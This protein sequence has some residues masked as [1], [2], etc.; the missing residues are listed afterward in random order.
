MAA[1]KLAAP[2]PSA[3]AM[4]A[5]DETA[6]DL[7][8]LL[9]SSRSSKLPCLDHHLPGQILSP[10]H[11]VVLHGEA[12]SGKSVLL[13]NVLAAQLLPVRCGGHG[14]PAVLIDAE[15]QCDVWLLAKVLQER[16]RAA[17]SDPLATSEAVT[18]ALGRL[19]IFRP[20]EPL[21]LLRQLQRLRQILRQNPTAGLLVI[22]SLSAWHSM[23]AAFPRST[24]ATLKECW[25]AVWRLM[26]EACVAAV[27]SHRD[28]Q[29]EFSL[30]LDAIHLGVGC[31]PKVVEEAEEGAPRGSQRE[32]FY[33]APW[34]KE[35]DTTDPQTA[36]TFFVIS[37]AGEVLSIPSLPLGDQ[38]VAVT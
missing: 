23:T 28:G 14:L 36:Q 17:A 34:G 4:V 6:Y 1:A 9:R 20:S 16:A 3:A 22:D 5:P 15:N 35:L 33:L 12:N 10:G 29:L 37:P 18:E 24:G 32:C 27:I 7:F 21:E 25:R 11:A 38:L 8:Q 2:A 31:C 26:R 19:L 13:R 30:E